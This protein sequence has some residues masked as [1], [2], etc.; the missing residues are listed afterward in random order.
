[1]DE[2]VGYLRSFDPAFSVPSP[3]ALEAQQVADAKSASQRAAVDAVIRPVV[4][5][6]S[7]SV[8]VA[9]DFKKGFVAGAVGGV[10]LTKEQ[11]AFLGVTNRSS[12]TR[13]GVETGQMVNMGMGP[14]GEMLSA[15]LSASSALFGSNPALNSEGSLEK[16]CADLPQLYDKLN[17]VD[18]KLEAVGLDRAERKK[19]EMSKA[20]LE[21]DVAELEKNCGKLPRHEPGTIGCVSDKRN[22]LHSQRE[23]QKTEK[24]QQPPPPPPK[25]K[26]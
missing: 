26:K 9:S 18:M 2:D 4:S 11:A 12:S 1:M 3:G 15:G 8:E 19:L 14:V 10:T 13:A 16:A 21:Q 24:K 17:T 20:E 22:E 25:E 23:E 7:S 5:V 6:M